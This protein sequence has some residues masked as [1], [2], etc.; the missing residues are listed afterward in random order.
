M[1]EYRIILAND[2]LRSYRIISLLVLA[3]NIGGIAWVTINTGLNLTWGYTVIGV[4]L[5]VNVLIQLMPG[6]NKDHQQYLYALAYA[7][8]VI[9]WLKWGI[10]WMAILVVIAYI[11]YIISRRP[12]LVSFTKD[13]ITYPSVPA[14]QIEWKEISQVILKDGLLTIDFRNNKVIQQMVQN[15]SELQ[16]KEFN[17]FCRTNLVAQLSKKPQG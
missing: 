13:H 6:M 12:M 1:E 9:A 7:A 2:K 5:L 4:V 11:L 15:D 17:D 14:R 8:I 3:I 16:E 10:Y